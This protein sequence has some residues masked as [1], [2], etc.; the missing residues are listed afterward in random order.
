[1]NSGEH[2]RTNLHGIVQRSLVNLAIGHGNEG[3][4]LNV[5]VHCGQVD[6]FAQW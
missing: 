4:A 3:V 6:F 5:G 2:E 1:M